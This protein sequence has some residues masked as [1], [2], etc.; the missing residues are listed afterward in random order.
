MEKSFRFVEKMYISLKTLYILGDKS[1]I[2]SG[3]KFN[4]KFC[5]W[6]K[7]KNILCAPYYQHYE[8]HHMLDQPNGTNA[9]LVKVKIPASSVAHQFD[10]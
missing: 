5:P 4:H 10:L 3:E 7:L 2:L 1:Y 9:L 8:K 6:R